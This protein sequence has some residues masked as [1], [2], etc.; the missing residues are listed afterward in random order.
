MYQHL[1]LT[2]VANTGETLERDNA[3]TKAISDNRSSIQEG[4]LTPNG[5]KYRF[6]FEHV[7]GS[8]RAYIDKHPSYQHRAKGAHSTHRYTSGSRK[9]VCWDRPLNTLAEVR[10]VAH[11][12]ARCT[13]TYISTGRWP[14]ATTRSLIDRFCDVIGW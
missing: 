6:T 1:L 11:H 4:Y 12:W 13:D 10:A 14:R 7:N 2:Q 8:W 3:M 5:N 9:Y